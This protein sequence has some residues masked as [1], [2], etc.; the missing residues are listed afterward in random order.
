M[1]PAPRQPP[2]RAAFAPAVLVALAFAVAGCH[3]A[4]SIVQGGDA[5][6]SPRAITPRV[7][8]AA[9]GAAAVV[10]IALDTQ[11]GVGRVGSFTGRLRFDAAGLRYDGSAP[12]AGLLAVNPAAGEVRVAGASANGL[13]VTRLAELRFTVTNPAALP[14]VR[15]EITE[16]HELSRADLRALLRPAAPP[17]IVR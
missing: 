12:A 13:D 7:S 5:A 1:T 10:T 9:T 8:I 6:T 16:M 15:F 2:R 11:G 4:A 17:R 3:D 14:G